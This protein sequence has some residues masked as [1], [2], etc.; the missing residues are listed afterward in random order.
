MKQLIPKLLTIV[1]AFLMLSSVIPA[2][3]INYDS[4]SQDDILPDSWN[5][6]FLQPTNGEF[7]LTNDYQKI[8][9]PNNIRGSTHAIAVSDDSEWM[10]T[11]GGYLNDRE[12]HIY[13]WVESIHQ[14]YPIFDAGDGIIQR[15]VLDVDF[16]DC[17]NN[18]RLEVVAGCADGRIYV[19]EQLGEASLPFDF[20]SPAH[21][22]EL[23]WDSGLYI[24][25]QVWSVVAYDIDHDSHDE[26]IAG[27]WDSKVYVFDYIDHSAYPYCLEEHWIEFRPVWDSGDIITDRVNSVC[28]VDSDNDRSIEI[29]AASHDCKV[30]LFEERPCMK[31]TYELRWT[32][33]DAFWAPVLSVTAS[34]NLDDDDYGE[35]VASAY[36]QAVIVFDYNQTIDDFKVRKINQGI[37]SWERGISLTTGVYTGYEADEWIDRK[38]YGWESQG[39][40]ENDPIPPPYNTVELGG[41]SALGGPWDDQETTFMSTEEF[42]LVREWKFEAGSELHQSIWPYAIA[43]APDGSIYVTDITN[44]RVVRYTETLEPILTWG[45]SGNESG[46]FSLPLGIAIDMDGFVYVADYNNHRIQKFTSEGEFIDSFGKNGTDK[47]VLQGPL[48]IAIHPD[49]LLY[50]SDY[51][52]DSIWVLNKTDGLILNNFGHSGASTGEFNEPGGVDFDIDDNL[53]VA[54]FLNDRIQVFH[55]NGTFLKTWGSTGSGPGD[56]DGPAAVT[57]DHD[58]RIYV[59]DSINKRIQKFSPSGDFESEWGSSGSGPGQFLSPLGICVSFGGILVV[60][61][62]SN[63]IQKFAVHEYELVKAYDI[64][65]ESLIA[66]TDVAFDSEG[67]YYVT[68]FLGNVVDKYAP[69]GTFILNWSV[70]SSWL[71]GIEVDQFDNVYVTDVTL[72]HVYIYNS[73][74][75]LSATFGGTGS[76]DGQLDGPLDVACLGDLF[77]VSEFDNDRISVFGRDT[78]FEYNFGTS[79]SLLGEF[80]GPYGLEFGPD[81]L[82]YVADRY[83][84][85]I[86]RFDP[87]GTAIDSWSSPDDVAFLAF[88]WQGNLYATGGYYPTL[89]KYSPEGNLIDVNDDEIA[90]YKEKIGQ[91]TGWGIEYR[92][93]NDSL[94]IADYTS[95]KIIMLRPYIALNNISEAVVDF[96]QWEEIGGDAT[97]DF[98]LVVVIEDDIDLENIELSI[99]NDLEEWIPLEFN[100]EFTQYLYYNFVF[101][102]Y[103]GFIFQDVDHALRAAKWDKFRYMKIGV[104]GGVTYDIDCAFGTVARPI[105]TAL[106]VTTGFIRTGSSSDD[107]EKI[108]VGTVDGEIMAYT[109]E[110]DFVWESQSD[111]PK[112]SLGSSIWDI[113][114]VKGKGMMPTWIEDDSL[115]TESEV[116]SDIPTFNDFISYSLVDIDGTSALDIVATMHVGVQARLVYFR[117]VGTNENPDYDY[118][119][120]YFVIHSTLITDQVYTHATVTMADLDGDYDDDMILCDA[121]QEPDSGWIITVRYFEQTSTDYWTERDDYLE[122]I[123]S[124][125]FFDNWLPR[126][127]VV[128]MNMDGMVDITLSMDKLYFFYQTSYSPGFKF[129]FYRDDSVY[130]TIND[131]KSNETVFGTVAYSDFDMDGD[132][133]IIVPHASENYTIRGYKCE[134]GRFTYWRNTGN[135]LFIE[136]TKT[137]SMF[138]PDFTGT[139]LNPERGHDYPMFRDMNEDGIPDL[140]CMKEDSIDLFLGTR[141][142]DSFLCA[143]YPYIHMVEVDK[144]TQS[145][146][147][148]GYEAYDSWTNWIIFESWSRSLEFG[149]VDMDGKPEVFV[150]SFDY[151]IIAFEQ[152]ANNTYRRSWR[153]FDFF[154]Q[155]WITGGT[156][157]IQMN[158]RDMV[159]G[160]QDNDGKQELIVCAG[161]NV[162]VFEAVENDFYELVW[163]SAPLT[164]T[165]YSP[166]H[167]VD[168]VPK[169]P[170]VVAVDKDLDGDKKPE[171]LVGAQDTL[172][173]FENVG[174][175]N[176]TMI[177]YKVFESMTR[178]S[179]GDPFIRGIMTDDINLDGARDIVIVGGDDVYSGGIFAYSIGWARYISNQLDADKNPINDQFAEFHNESLQSAA[180]CVD[181]ADHDLDDTPEIFIGTGYGVT[182]YECDATGLPILITTL[183]T[184]DA[185][186]AVRV[187]NTDGDSWYEV[188]AGTGKNLTVFEQNQT[189]DRNLHVYDNI[190]N[191]GELHEEISD[192]RLGDSNLNNRTEII[193]TAIKG[194]LYSYEWVANSSAIGLSPSFSPASMSSDLCNDSKL[195]C[196]NVIASLDNI[197]LNLK[198]LFEEKNWRYVIN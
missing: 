22:W 140:I 198:R 44:N 91:V 185:T 29:V 96:G 130:Q 65:H 197:Y 84:Y 115:L 141:D 132:I 108:I 109:G 36:G 100:N 172:F 51:V 119:P 14:Y 150:G 169:Q 49:G 86:Q 8:W 161:M 135:R 189:Y 69:D 97:N 62:L 127:S 88:D 20:L 12:V 152:V 174:D 19:F 113:V 157:P 114:Q 107:T 133:D 195:S 70:P 128:D 67:N 111:Q 34:Q 123:E 191:S 2:G 68:G 46:N 59:T 101:L 32:S 40:Y 17:D 162:Y 183:S 79:G 167:R 30:Y 110:G 58:G 18:G 43:S 80:N 138:E 90:S 94:Y 6:S 7:N 170:Y 56:L 175:N 182:I 149:D 148:W 171:I 105:T 10:A 179:F 55:P 60:D 103:T 196:N 37:K 160:D 87:N 143:T 159:I 151:N 63:R 92:A 95:K 48:D 4:K 24:D 28:V 177:G 57:V 112:F 25:R 137:R 39:I 13:R 192:I 15:D 61:V 74:G 173:F 45:S 126:I 21:Q 66:P 98:D 117:N 193:A 78:G 158:I 42:Q 163:V 26:I 131:D 3:I 72:N 1:L 194:Y 147:Y 125:V 142:H 35:I 122:D 121:G 16:M 166:T 23:V 181:I 134:S 184:N 93:D 176:Y 186:K 129:H 27:A 99:S 75:N 73:M 5:D 53:L 9:E 71:F 156:L 118:M 38:V 82:L 77:F 83:N 136:W 89:K 81:G 54:D 85:R 31:H 178:K 187:G 124:V 146:G 106:V 41:A 47:S 33:G 116:L 154:L 145:D 120:N 139:L 50:V 144:R 11:A 104:K 76:G 64:N 102:G 188:V 153:S 190:W 155:N 52:N 165:P 168:P 164:Y 180:Y